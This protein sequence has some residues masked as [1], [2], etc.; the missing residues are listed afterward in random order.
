M[1]AREGTSFFPSGSPY[2]YTLVPLTQNDQ[3]WHMKGRGVFLVSFVP[4]ILRGPSV[5]KIFGTLPTPIWFDLE[6]LHSVR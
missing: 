5:P 3:I 4:L 6:R 2:V 1:A